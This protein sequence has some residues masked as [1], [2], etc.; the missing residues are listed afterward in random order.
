MSKG[1]LLQGMGRGKLGDVVFYRMDGQQMARVRNRKP[2]NPRT[3]GQLAQ[4][5]I[6]ATILRAYAAGKEIFDHSFEGKKVGMGNQRVF[7]SENLSKLR[8]ALVYDFEVKPASHVNAIVNGPKTN[9]PVPN[10]YTISKGTLEG[11]IFNIIDPTQAGPTGY[12]TIQVPQAG[13][14]VSEFANRIGLKVGDIYTFCGFTA[15]K[16]QTVFT[17]NNGKGSGA[18]QEW[19]NF[20]YVRFICTDA[21][22]SDSPAADATFGDLF[23]IDATSNVRTVNLTNAKF[24]GQ[25]IALS[26]LFGMQNPDAY[27]MAIGVIRSAVNSPLRS[28]ATLHWVDWYNVVGIDWQ[29]LFGAWEKEANSIAGSDLI[30]EGADEGAGEYEPVDPPL[31]TDDYTAISTEGN[32]LAATAKNGSKVILTVG[33]RAILATGGQITLK[34]DGTDGDQVSFDDLGTYS[35]ALQQVPASIDASNVSPAPSGGMGNL[36]IHVAGTTFTA[37]N[38]QWQAVEGETAKYNVSAFKVVL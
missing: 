10:L 18:Y 11:G 13:E 30:L 34:H 7:M 3:K 5:A 12:L 2:D 35:G 8:Q 6:M 23:E 16:T 29:N 14:S 25:S 36:N 1:N 15:D 4:R 22:N 28:N 26:S 32:Y 27:P 24:D 33:G 38:Q 20:F 37:E 21:I 19:G 9:T 17:V 31:P